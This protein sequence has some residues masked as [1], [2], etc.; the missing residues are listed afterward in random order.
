MICD[1]GVLR[2]NVNVILNFKKRHVHPF[3]SDTNRRFSSS[4]TFLF[5][6]Q[7]TEGGRPT[8]LTRKVTEIHLLRQQSV[9]SV[10]AEYQDKQRYL[11]RLI[12]LFRLSTLDDQC[13]KPDFNRP[14]PAQR[15]SFE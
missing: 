7:F 12:N 1:V 3:E 15:V 4:L 2:V 10:T 11:L 5:T 9:K 14:V 6:G 13:N 8:F